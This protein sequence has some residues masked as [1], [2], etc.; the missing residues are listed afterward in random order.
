MTRDGVLMLVNLTAIGYSSFV[1][2]QTPGFELKVLE[3][4]MCHDMAIGG[5][6]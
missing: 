3:S 4:P 1:F 2:D 6:C 5:G